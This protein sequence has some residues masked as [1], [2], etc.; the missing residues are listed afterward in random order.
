MLWTP[1]QEQLE[2]SRVATEMRDRDSVFVFGSNLGGY[3]GGG[4]AKYAFDHYGA[5]WGRAFGIQGRSYAV[6]TKTAGFQTMALSEIQPYLEKLWD[7]AVMTYGDRRF[8]VTR[9]GC[10][11]AGLTD[12][13]MMSILPSDRPANIFL[14]PHWH[15]S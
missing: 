2:L 8:I 11:L 12:E 14:P 7:E 4:A 6:P 9:I 1:E 3:H 13:Q 5:V 10:G 15:W